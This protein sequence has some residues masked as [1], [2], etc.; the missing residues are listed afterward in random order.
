MFRRFAVRD[1]LQSHVK[2]SQICHVTPYMHR[3]A[4]PNNA[5]IPYRQIYGTQTDQQ[6]QPVRPYSAQCLKS[7]F[8]SV[9]HGRR[10]YASSREAPSPSPSAQPNHHHGDETSNSSPALQQHLSPTVPPHNN[11]DPQSPHH[12]DLQS[13]LA[14]ARRQ[15]LDP[16]STVYRGTYYEYLVQ[17][18]LRSYG[19]DLT[20]T[21]GRGDGGVDMVGVWRLPDLVRSGSAVTTT[22]TTGTDS[23][24]TTEDTATRNA[25]TNPLLATEPAT[26]EPSPSTTSHTTSLKVL[27]QCKRLT[28]SSKLGPSLIRELE[29]ALRNGPPGWRDES[30]VMGILVA[31]KP[32]TKGLRDAMRSA[33]R[34]VCWICLEVGEEPGPGEVGTSSGTDGGVSNRDTGGVEDVSTQR[35][36]DITDIGARAHVPKYTVR[37]IL[38]NRAADEL[39]LL[40][41]DA[42]VQHSPPHD[43]NDMKGT[44][45]VVLSRNGVVVAG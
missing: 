37:Q 2:G 8:A 18:A 3:L 41:L 39:G 10:R 6:L 23:S 4:L 33:R 7:P 38:W 32:A 16:K 19:M 45:R 28:S 25:A 42:T 17:A 1:S 11:P 12:H 13:F 21:G 36:G 9:K 5:A 35:R 26:A 15:A 20:R 40:G 27:V 34:A 22:G 14:H 31:T 24:T 43:E 29:G 44:S 30:H